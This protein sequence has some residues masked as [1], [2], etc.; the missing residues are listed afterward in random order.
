MIKS[1]PLLQNWLQQS[2]KHKKSYNS[3]KKVKLVLCL[4][5]WFP[6]SPIAITCH[7]PLADWPQI[8]GLLSGGMCPSLGVSM[9]KDAE[10]SIIGR[11][12]FLVG[13]RGEGGACFYAGNETRFMWE[14]VIWPTAVIHQEEISHVFLCEKY[15]KTDKEFTDPLP[16]GINLM[17]L[18]SDGVIFV[19][20][21]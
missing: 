6:V 18:H 1:N 20:I 3:Y 15:E 10:K 11:L 4:S 16:K 14:R 9:E 12:P 13:R 19:G 8:T 21:K 7:F 17:V 5:G 2:S